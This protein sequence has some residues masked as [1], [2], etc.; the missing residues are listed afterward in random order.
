ML[1]ALRTAHAKVLWETTLEWNSCGNERE[2]AIG[3]R[4]VQRFMKRDGDIARHL[5][6]AGII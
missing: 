5:L 1:I 2:D 4:L 6:Y 3:L